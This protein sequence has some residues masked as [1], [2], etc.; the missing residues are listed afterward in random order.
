MSPSIS[1]SRRISHSSW[2]RISGEERVF[3]DGLEMGEMN[4][5]MRV[6]DIIT[7]VNILWGINLIAFVCD[8]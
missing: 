4:G 7:L 2:M 5:V 3:S 6:M 1:G 8:I